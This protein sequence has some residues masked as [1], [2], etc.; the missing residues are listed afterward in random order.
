[1]DVKK[2][3]ELI[4]QLRR[5]QGLNQGELATLLGVTNKAI[6]RW[7]TGR[8]YP[9]IE[10]LPKLAEVLN[11]SI[12]ELLNGERSQ[13]SETVV[14]NQQVRSELDKSLETVCQYAGEQSRKQK[15]QFTL[16]N[17]LVSLG[18]LL[19][20][21]VVLAGEAI[22]GVLDFVDTVGGFYYSIVGSADCVIADDY[23]SLTYL[24]KTYVPLPV[25]GYA[26][27]E[28]QT[29]VEECQVEG[30]GFL[31][32][33]FFGEKLYEIKNVPNQEMVY[34]QTDYDN[35]VSRYFVLETR[36]DHYSRLVENAVFDKF[37]ATY[38]N[39]SSYEWER[40]ISSELATAI[41]DAAAGEAVEDPESGRSVM[42]CVFDETHCFYYYAGY[43]R[44]TPSG[45]YWN[46]VKHSYSVSV[47]WN[48]TKLYYPIIGFDEEL[49]RIFS[50]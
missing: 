46:P 47:G 15:K 35:C 39:E 26:A 19:A 2:T 3:G 33:L 6:S 21:V 43:L 45:Y 48:Y 16:M 4:S 9:D 7:E 50:N 29:M 34:L 12:P 42:V 10:T 25:N 31:G 24:G 37:Y 38:R 30:I 49:S 17:V 18:L 11:V 8:G 41:A 40:P 13:V 1:M 32:K 27:A 44:Q 23:Q 5:E 36:Y 22:P 28:G 14:L 20:M